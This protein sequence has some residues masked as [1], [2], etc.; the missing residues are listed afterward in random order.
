MI[1]SLQSFVRVFGDTYCVTVLV[2]PA[3]DS[4][5]DMWSPNF[6]AANCTTTCVRYI[7]VGQITTIHQVMLSLLEKLSKDATPKRIPGIPYTDTWRLYIC[8]VEQILVIVKATELMDSN[9]HKAAPL[10]VNVLYRHA[11]APLAEPHFHPRYLERGR[12]TL[13]TS[14]LFLT[15]RC[16]E[17]QIMSIWLRFRSSVLWDFL[18]TAQGNYQN[19]RRQRL[20]CERSTSR[21]RV[22]RYFSRSENSFSNLIIPGEN[23]LKYT[24]QKRRIRNKRD[25]SFE[26]KVEILN[27]DDLKVSA[28]SMRR[29]RTEMSTTSRKIITRSK[30]KSSSDRSAQ[31]QIETSEATS[32]VGA[33]V[34]NMMT[35]RVVKTL[36]SKER[37]QETKL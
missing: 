35:E 12:K 4:V 22:E 33:S 13:P 14:V 36:E 29:S 1:Q 20:R 19:S 17:R 24:P 15:E 9:D 3:M 23:V 21:R 27:L 10:H 37:S 32:L 26:G 31:Q 8:S 11:S 34:M 28:P 18:T 5:D 16:S 25:E 7:T 30:K 2:V 6:F